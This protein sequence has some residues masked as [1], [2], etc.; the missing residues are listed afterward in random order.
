VSTPGF[1]H[2]HCH[3]EYSLLDGACRIPDLV[4]ETRAHELEALALTDHG[5]LFGAIEFYRTAISSGIKPILG[6]EVYVAPGDRRE[7]RA[8]GGEVA[9]HLI[10]LARDAT[11]YRNLMKLSS[12][13]FLDG[14]YYRPR[15]DKALLRDH[16]E[17]LI[18]ASACLQG[19]I[20]VHNVAGR[21]EEAKK[22]ALEYQDIFGEGNFYLEVQNHE[23]EAELRNID[24]MISLSRELD[25]PLI[26]SNDI[27]YMKPEHAESHEV[28]L[29]V[30]TGKTLDDVDRM[31]S[32]PNL[33]YRSPAEMAELFAGVPEAL[34][35][36][37][38]IARRCNLLLEFDQMHLP[39]YPLPARFSTLQEYLRHLAFEGA[40]LRYAAIEDQVEARL[41][42]ELKT[43]EQMGFAGYFLIVADFTRKAR[44]MGIPVGPGR[45]SAAGSIVSYCLGITDIDPIVYDLL[46][47]RFLNP[48]RVSMP[49]I[50]IDFCYERRSEII[51]Y[52]VEKY[53]EESVAQIITFGTMAA[54]A[55]VRDV[56][57]V[58]GLPYSEVD[59]VAKMV[60]EEL[61]I[62]LEDAIR[63][64]T[65]LQELIEAEE[66]YRKLFDH[67]RVL[68]GLARHASTHAAGVVIAPGLLT[69]FVPLYKGSKGEVTTQYSMVPL[70][71]VGLLKVDFLGLR[72]LTV[73]QDAVEL[74][75]R[76]HGVKVDLEAVDL[77]DRPTYALFSR[78]ETTGIFQFE[79]SGM[80]EYLH[81]LQPGSLED[82]I[83]MN[84]LYRPGPL[85]ANMV[86]DF[87]ERK[88]GRKRITYDHPLLEP[89][90]KP[91]YGIIVYQEQVMRI[92]SELAG[93]TLGEADLLRRAMGK[94]KAEVMEEQRD[95][96]LT[97]A[98]KRDIDE[99]I[100]GAIFEQMA[101]FAG[102]GFNR[103]HSAGYALV[104]Y[105]TGYL[106]AH[107][108]AEFMAASLSSEMNNSDRVVILIEECRRLELDVASPDINE[109]DDKFMVNSDGTI[110]FGLGAVK[111]VGHGA[112]AA[113]VTARSE[114]GPFTS[115]V[116]F[117]ERIDLKCVNRRVVESLIAAGA[118]DGLGGH[119][120]QLIA[121]AQGQIEGAH[122]RQIERERGQVSFFDEGNGGALPEIDTLPEMPEWPAV[123][124]LAR[125]KEALGFYVSGHPLE[126]YRDEVIAFTNARLGEL[127]ELADNTSV[128]VAG[129]IASLSRKSDRNGNPIAFAGLEDFTGSTE[130]IVFSDPWQTYGEYMHEDA[131][132]LLRARVSKKE[133]EAP[134]LIAEEVMPLSEARRRLTGRLHLLLVATNGKDRAGEALRII[135][136]YPGPI[137][138]YLHV[139]HSDEGP[140]L[141]LRAEGV[142]VDTETD[143]LDELK[144]LLGE[145]NVWVS[146]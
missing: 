93:F 126:R 76:R 89:I 106:K 53:G 138:V 14:F 12:A 52:V 35:N 40:R 131:M 141:K 66:R 60:P 39:R 71:K 84:A 115:L 34:T 70:E 122:R 57:R 90:L 17:G 133:G 61:G 49:D 97:G 117:L 33:Y 69:D 111:N 113:I 73:L 100:A 54:R 91:T 121:A 50:D 41:E 81:K 28:L 3:S 132:V 63:Q 47:E 123:E 45:G 135:S 101:Y 109:S 112:I 9:Y 65:R 142:G 116:D 78:G 136:R 15:V 85:G 80:R 23:I 64:E 92:A 43:I 27:H 118:C 29:C 8:Q 83:A 82:L 96:F 22:A 87:I 75:E 20:A 18:A 105:R 51:R 21:T 129:V 125:E 10:L 32:N 26:A 5:V 114:G 94:K 31:T 19:E 72:T 98:R 48:E 128:V 44:E 127:G 62:K 104:A 124:M 99:R 67:A 55:A 2:L 58:M 95:A 139:E 143:L 4:A 86:D 102:Y 88:H 110:R 77:D 37:T 134:K 42:Y 130:A 119:R 11:G 46:F 108:P 24:A 74:I 7:R 13:G 36:T 16:S 145:E 6:C 1:V 120:A 68:E 59:R 79:S 38:E 140:P 103:S 137:P 30:Q 107:Y 146:S 25:I 56:G 144:D